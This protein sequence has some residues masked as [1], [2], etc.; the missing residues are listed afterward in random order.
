MGRWKESISQ[1]WKAELPASAVNAAKSY[2]PLSSSQENF[3]AR[4][5]HATQLAIMS[6]ETPEGTNIG[7][8]KILHCLQA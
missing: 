4:N 7:L 1:G 2:N 3:E 5:T 8:R 6:A